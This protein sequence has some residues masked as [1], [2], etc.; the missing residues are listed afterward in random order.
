VAAAKGLAS[1]GTLPGDRF[2]VCM[3][4]TLDQVVAILLGV[5]WANAI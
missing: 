5:P 1:L 2:G 3:Q 4:K